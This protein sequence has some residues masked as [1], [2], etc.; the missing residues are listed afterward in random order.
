MK[1]YLKKAFI[2]FLLLGAVSCSKD[3]L[4]QYD[5][6][7][8]KNAIQSL[9]EKFLLSSILTKTTLFY[10]NMN[11]GTT[12]LPGAVQYTER[13]FQGGDNTYQGFKNL[14]TDLYS[15]MAILKFIDASIKQVDARGLKSYVGIFT[16]F[17]VL[18]FS[19]ITDFYGDIYY[20]QAL[21]GR[22]GILYPAYDKQADIYTGLLNELDGASANITAGTESI[23][24]GY[25]LMFGGDK[26]QWLKFCNS[27]KL[28]LLMHASAKL[29]DAGT[30][31]SA[32]VAS[33]LLTDASDQNASISYVGTNAA[34]SWVGWF[35]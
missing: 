26:N 16:T 33:S 5:T 21:Q 18:L 28:R 8:Q 32:V 12:M 34:N 25:D 19:F 30:R 29:T 23:N 22:E 9:E 10:Q 17:R 27:L 1:S 7:Q 13:N 20:T 24:A 11:W 14:P 6:L 3:D 31:I 2:I 15:A 4:R 35:E